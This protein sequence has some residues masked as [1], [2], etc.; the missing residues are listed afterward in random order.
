MSAWIEEGLH[1]YT[2]LC[3]LE[4]SCLLTPATA[5]SLPKLKEVGSG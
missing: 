1:G 3:Y 4:A 2:Y 5:D